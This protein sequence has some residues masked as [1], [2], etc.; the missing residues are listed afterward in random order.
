MGRARRAIVSASGGGAEDRATSSLLPPLARS[1][2][3][4]CR[5]G[6]RGAARVARARGSRD[7]DAAAPRDRAHGAGGATYR[8]L[9]AL[10]RAVF[11]ASIL[12]SCF[13][14]AGSRERIGAA[15]GA[16]LDDGVDVEECE[17]RNAVP[18][19][20]GRE[21]WGRSGVAM[22]WILGNLEL[23]RRR[24]K[25]EGAGGGTTKSD[26]SLSS[27]LLCPAGPTL[28]PPRRDVSRY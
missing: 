14:D 7:D 21:L 15:G 12:A 11:W 3:E 17:G 10:A 24:R 26:A 5:A 27:V 20:S 23:G 8:R 13:W 2:K 16:R 6:G 4:R 25:G 22:N 19:G 1:T 9:E 18:R 28:S